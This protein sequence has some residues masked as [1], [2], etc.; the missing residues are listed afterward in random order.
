MQITEVVYDN[1]FIENEAD[2]NFVKSL[3][4]T[5]NV[6]I[7]EW[8]ENKKTATKVTGNANFY[9]VKPLDTFESVSKKLNI[10]IQKLKALAGTKHLYVGQKIE[11]LL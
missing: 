11:K 8:W 4:P 6:Q 9:I 7:G 10:S 1:I 3:D 5:A 2:L